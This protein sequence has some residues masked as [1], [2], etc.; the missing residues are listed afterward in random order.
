MTYEVGNPVPGLGQEQ[1][2]L[3]NG[4]CSRFNINI[5]YLL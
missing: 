1:K 2:L 3:K 4:V 5:T